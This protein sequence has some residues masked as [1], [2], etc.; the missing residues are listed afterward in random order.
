MSCIE[1]FSLDRTPGPKPN[2]ERLSTPIRNKMRKM[3]RKSQERSKD[4]DE[5]RLQ[6]QQKSCNN[7]TKSKGKDVVA[8]RGVYASWL[9]RGECIEMKID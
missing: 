2:S 1:M 3:R 6:Q 5:R 7:P 8:C 4:N 9:L